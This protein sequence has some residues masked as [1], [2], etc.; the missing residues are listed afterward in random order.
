M[1]TIKDAAMPQLTAVDVLMHPVRMRIMVA[2]AGQQLTAQ[3]LMTLLPDIAQ[4]TL[5]R[6]LSVLTEQQVLEVVEERPVRGTVDEAHARRRQRHL[7]T[8]R[9]G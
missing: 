1:I 7:R 3:Q 6:H 8:A 9:T 2:L 4:A 5:Y